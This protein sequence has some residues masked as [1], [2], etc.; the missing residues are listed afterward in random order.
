[1]NKRLEQQNFLEH[2]LLEL[3]EAKTMER[4]DW[5]RKEPLV[6][7]HHVLLTFAKG[8]GILSINGTPIK[9]TR[10][11][12]FLLLPGTNVESNL[13][14]K[15]DVEA[16]WV[17]F[18]LFRQVEATE[19]RRVYER[20][21]SFPVQGLIANS[22]TRLQRLIAVLVTG[23]K[24]AA[25]NNR[26]RQLENLHVLLDKVMTDHL[27]RRTEGEEQ[28][29]QQTV[30]YIQENYQQEIKV[31]R[32]AEM[33]GMHPAYY[34]QLFKREMKKTPI[35]YLTQLRMNKAKE[36]LLSASPDKNIREIASSVGYRDEFYFSRRFKESSGY[37]PTSY[38][39]SRKEPSVIS[40]SYPYTEHL[41][42][43]GI[44][45]CAAHTHPHLLID[46]ISLPLPNHALEMWEISRQSFVETKPDLIVCKDHVLTKAREHLGDIAPIFSVSWNQTDTFGHLMEIAHLVD[47]KREART[48]LDRHT[49]K[50]ESIRKKVKAL[51]GKATVAICVVCDQAYRMY[52]TRNIGHVFYRSLELGVPE[53]IQRE[54]IPHPPGTHFNWV[55]MPKDELPQYDA[56]FLFFV[57]RSEEEVKMVEYDIRTMES[58]KNHSAIAAGRYAFLDW[59]KWMVYAPLS[60]EK[61][62]EESYDLFVSIMDQS[63]SIKTPSKNALFL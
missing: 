11:S 16:H 1:M 39:K 23:H 63:F 52:S 54:L 60:I 48:W 10:K 9:I 13:A 7:R 45:P 26:M 38:K 46:T 15:E 24:A 33:A 62:L 59:Y 50:A 34:S 53:K 19:Q 31:E 18:D 40:L 3:Y 29:L 30:G 12:I 55:G 32:L 43:L 2:T 58:W 41:L 4:A 6:L 44:T 22:H 5:E 57:V 56:D 36:L 25:K 21:Q 27:P 28:W 35:E 49:K 51:L 37:S 61:Q 17:S 8:K 14:D 20:E 47:R 42:A